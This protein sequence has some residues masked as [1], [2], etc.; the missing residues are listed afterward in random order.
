MTE[1][2]RL[3]NGADDEV[4]LA[5]LRSAHEDAPSRRA[6]QGAMV[7]LG[8]ATAGVA[9]ASS[10][11]AATATA[12]GL[13]KASVAPAAAQTGT[14]A[15]RWGAILVKW[16]G[17]AAVGG[18]ASWGVAEQLT[19]NTQPLAAAVVVQE[20]ARAEVVVAAH[21]P[22]AAL[23]Q[24]AAEDAE[25]EPAP[26]AAEDASPVIAPGKAKPAKKASLS[27]EL[28]AL[29]KARK[30]MADDPDAALAAVEA[31]EKKY[32]GGILAEEAEVLR[33]ESLARA[34]KKDAAKA[35]AS[36]FLARHPQSTFAARV[37]A[38]AL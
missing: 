7:A 20:G 4:A 5:L 10:A 33:V 6:R 29:D 9:T 15:I 18:L 14:L 34:G 37:R 3:L 1:P 38:L 17:I 22:V 21:A 11:G 23:A 32:K 2:E 13:A 28:A 24:P 31:Y 16:V 27:E 8:I 26:D 19:P 12:A 30:A 36:A 35:A 25:E